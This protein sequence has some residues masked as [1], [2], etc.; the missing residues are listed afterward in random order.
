MLNYY[1]LRRG[2]QFILDGQPHEVLEFQQIKKARAAGL[3][4]A[5]IKNLITGKVLE[6]TFH[7]GDNFE[8]TEIEKIS[9][10]IYVNKQI[11]LP[12]RRSLKKI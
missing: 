9:A 1:D 4:Q 6:R 8:E 7:Q 12:R 10:K 2:V 5:K 11:P 3:L